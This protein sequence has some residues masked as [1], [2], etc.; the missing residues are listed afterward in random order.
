LLETAEKVPEFKAWLAKQP[1]NSFDA[2][3][4][5]V[6][7]IVKY[8]HEQGLIEAVRSG[9]LDRVGTLP[10]EAF[11]ITEESQSFDQA[12]GWVDKFPGR[13]D[14]LKQIVA[15]EAYR[16]VTPSAVSREVLLRILATNDKIIVRKLLSINAASRDALLLLPDSSV[17][18]LA[19]KLDTALLEDLGSYW[20]LLEPDQRVQ[21]ARVIIQTPSL[22]GTFA[23]PS[24][25][26]IVADAPNRRGAIAFFSQTSGSMIPRLYQVASEIVDVADGS[27][28]ASWFYAKYERVFWPVAAILVLIVMGPALLWRLLGFVWRRIIW[29]KGAAGAP[30]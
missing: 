17:M 11:V 19:V 18:D 15:F 22:A 9:L 7:V 27:V 1:E 12:L 30:K 21:L 16:Y 4:R 26:S 24:V 23:R 29:R 2:V 28:P 20:R 5:T 13:P 3:A 6:D 8:R 10:E 14:R 25:R